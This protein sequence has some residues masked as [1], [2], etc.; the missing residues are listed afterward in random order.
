MKQWLRNFAYRA[1]LG[2]EIFVLSGLLALIIA[3]GTI[4]YQSFREGLGYLKVKSCQKMA[5]L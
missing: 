4:G 1:S 2:I 5:K 3:L